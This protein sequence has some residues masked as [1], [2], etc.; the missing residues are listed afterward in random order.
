M[1]INI[2][3]HKK[4]HPRIPFTTLI[5]KY[6]FKFSNFMTDII[7]SQYTPYVQKI[8]CMLNFS[9]WLI[10]LNIKLIIYT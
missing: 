2:I 6:I 10:R 7:L 8:E 3:H 5:L 9:K 1:Y 4:I